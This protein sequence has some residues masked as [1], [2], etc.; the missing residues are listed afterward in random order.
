M[1]GRAC[2]LLQAIEEHLPCYHPSNA[3]MCQHLATALILQHKQHAGDRAG[4]GASSLRLKEALRMYTKAWSVLCVAYGKEHVQTL[5]AK[6]L[7]DEARR[8]NKAQI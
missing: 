3:H 6:E 2:D 1:G 4:D 5:Q 8:L 7:V